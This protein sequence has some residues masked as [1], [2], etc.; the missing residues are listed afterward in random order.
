[1]MG[2]AVQIPSSIGVLEEAQPR[3]TWDQAPDSVSAQSTFHGGLWLNTILL[4]PGSSQTGVH[5][6]GSGLGH[7]EEGNVC[8]HGSKIRNWKLPPEIPVQVEQGGLSVLR[9][10]LAVGS[11]LYLWKG[12]QKPQ[13]SKISGSS[14]SKNF[15]IIGKLL[16]DNS[17]LKD[18]KMPPVQGLSK[19]LVNELLE[20]RN[21]HFPKA[22]GDLVSRVRRTWALDRLSCSFFFLSTRGPWAN[23]GMY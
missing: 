2:D 9:M 12:G 19:Y 7:H 11:V 10:A 16:T 4:A 5:S 17:C 1:M 20:G 13:D 21:M 14:R 23:L 8:T 22:P 6:W 18:A 3:K 15:V